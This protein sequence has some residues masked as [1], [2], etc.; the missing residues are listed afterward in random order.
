MATR[1]SP[2]MFGVSDSARYM[3]KGARDFSFAF[4]H[5]EASRHFYDHNEENVPANA[6]RVQR[7][8][9]DASATWMLTDRDS[10]TV[11]LPFQTGTFD[12]SPIP[13]HTGSKDKASGIGDLA[14][15]WR[16]W[17][18]D[19]ATHPHYNL[20]LGLGLKLPTGN[21]EAQ[22]D[23]YVNVAPAGSPPSFAWRRGPADVAI[24][25]GDGG[26]GIILSAEGFHE[27]TP[28]SLLF[29]EV[30]YLLNPRG[31]NGVNNQ[32]SGAGPYVPNSTTSVPDYFL[33]RMGV[34]LAE[35]FGWQRASVQLGLRIEGQPPRDLIGSNDGF[36]RPGYSLS[37]EPGVAY[38]FGTWNVFVSVPTTLYR[39]RWRSVDEKRAGR[40]NAVSAA[41]A[42][43][44][45]LA[46]VNRRW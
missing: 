10:V 25:P 28:K 31:D 45:I 2:P 35:P 21:D 7:T 14:V 4:R 32:W 26:L 20:R 18:F 16:R 36:R 13:P 40:S 37:V 1:V 24:Q 22:T 42:D 29:G 33:G 6:P 41:F 11:S 17:I 15:T 9:Y 39:V 12:R 38:S 8:T 27:L 19:P 34:A 46:G 23:R 44:N 43:H 30:T 5:Y 3:E